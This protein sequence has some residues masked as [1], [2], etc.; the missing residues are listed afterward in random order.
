MIS[1]LSVELKSTQIGS[2]FEAEISSF[3][4]SY[5]PKLNRFFCLQ[6]KLSLLSLS[7]SCLIKIKIDT[8]KK[9]KEKYGTKRFYLF[10]NGIWYKF[11][12]KA[13]ITPFLVITYQ[14][15]VHF[16]V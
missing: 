14:K 8:G 4:L 16:F 7:M 12:K 15:G 1:L 2:L 3:F 11:K 6:L 10:L 13:L 5:Q 9:V